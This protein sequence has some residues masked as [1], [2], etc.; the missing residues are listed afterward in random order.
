MSYRGR[1]CTRLP[2]EE[3]DFIVISAYEIGHGSY[4]TIAKNYKEKFKKPITNSMVNRIIHNS[5]RYREDYIR[6][7]RKKRMKFL[8][9]SSYIYYSNYPL[10]LV[11]SEDFCIKHLED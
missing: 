11:F 8:S 5:Q 2:D 7:K 10:S 4:R 9:H 6:P 3:I 1:G